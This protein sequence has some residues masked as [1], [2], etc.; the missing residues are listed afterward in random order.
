MKFIKKRDLFLLEEL[1]KRNF[2]SKYK[3]SVLGILWTV[4]SPLLMMALFTIIFSTIFGRNID[5]FPVYFLCGWCIFTFFNTSVGTSMM[6]LKGNENIL[7]RTP[8]PKYVFVLASVISEFLNFIIM[9]LLLVCVMIVTHA[10][11]HLTSIL[12]V[13]PIISLVIMVTGLGL[14][15]SVACVY[16]T[17]VKHLWTVFSMML[18][19]ASGV[20]YPM[21]IIPEPYHKYMIL[22]P[23]YWII[24]QFRCFIYHGVIPELGYVLNS[25]ILSS[26]ILVFGII[27]FVAYEYKLT[28]KF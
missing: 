17:D 13:I 24:D 28:M 19:Y 18:M 9:F 14:I 25:L 8:T 16:Y 22:N 5:N 12:A 10:S 23:V 6:A 1:V 2:S 15:L 27:I 4:L 7:K 20:F 11:F 26:I 21:D 3:D